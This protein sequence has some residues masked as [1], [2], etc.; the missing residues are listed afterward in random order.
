MGNN[1]KKVGSF[2]IAVVT[3]L[4]LLLGA[5]SADIPEATTAPELETESPTQATEPAAQEYELLWPDVL[6]YLG[7]SR[8]TH[9]LVTSRLTLDKEV[10]NGETGYYGEIAVAPEYRQLLEDFI[11]LI[12]DEYHFELVELRQE[13]IYFF[14]FLG[15]NAP[16]AVHSLQTDYHCFVSIE[17]GDDGI[18]HVAYYWLDSFDRDQL[19]AVE[20]DE[21]TKP[22]ETVPEAPTESRAT[23]P[24]ATQPKETKPAAL[25][26]VLPDPGAFL[27]GL[28][29][30]EDHEAGQ[31][32]WHL[33]YKMEIDEGYRAAHEY[34]DLL[35]D[36]R[37][38]LVMR[39]R[40]ERDTETIL[41]L[42]NEWYSF[43]YVGKEAVTP[44][45]SSYYQDGYQNYSADVFVSIQKNTDSKYTAIAIEFS[46]DLKVTDLGDRASNAQILSPG[47]S[48]GSGSS[49]G[50]S[51]NPTSRVQC[52]TCNGTGNCQTCGGD[53]Y[54]Y[55]SA[56]KKEDRNCTS[57]HPNRG[58]CRSCGGDGWL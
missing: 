13:E 44:V 18:L 30:L 58:R 27:G 38:Q 46:D 57:C 33:S 5:C 4:V 45:K 37:F 25:G 52:G 51:F 1:S 21:G 31:D 40:A 6:S 7:E 16:D 22:Q 49:G 8:Y 35:S 43:D 9:E 29:P 42:T 15:E 34:L 23:E 36:S 53:G 47:G 2:L 48:G 20:G 41:Y 39:P 56:S 14:R 54:L 3:A 50:S 12:Q 10:N 28:E 19:A 17:E 11:Q 32:G 55:S 26:A 24:A